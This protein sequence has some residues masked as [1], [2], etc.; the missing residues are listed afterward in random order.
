MCT[1]LPHDPRGG[2]RNSPTD[3]EICQQLSQQRFIRL[4]AIRISLH[5]VRAARR[6]VFKYF[7][8]DSRFDRKCS[9]GILRAVVNIK[10]HLVVSVLTVVLGVV[11]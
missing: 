3:V 11:S 8:E 9:W 10:I 5:S 4:N 6:L 7:R 1:R 2:L